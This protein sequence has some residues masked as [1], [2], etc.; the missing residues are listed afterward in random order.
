MLNI[1]EVEDNA[2]ALEEHLVDEVSLEADLMLLVWLL[3][4]TLEIT[5]IKLLLVGEIIINI[6]YIDL[7]Q[8]LVLLANC[9]VRIIR[10]ANCLDFIIIHSWLWEL[11]AQL[12]DKDS[13]LL[14]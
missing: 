9:K 1:L 14:T 12:A 5:G 7:I 13:Y 3:E 8:Q 4:L 2:V 11:I 6:T 10:K